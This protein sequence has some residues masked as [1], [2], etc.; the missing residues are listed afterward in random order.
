MTQIH[1]ASP[2]LAMRVLRKK[3]VEQFINGDKVVTE[4]EVVYEFKGGNLFLD[5]GTDVLADRH[6]PGEG[7]VEQDA[8]SY[9]RNHPDLGIRFKEITPVAPDPGPVYADIA[10]AV[11]AGDIA[12]LEAIGDDEFETW[13]RDEVMDRVRAAL[14][15]LKP[16]E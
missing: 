8:I 2:H 11:I 16:K 5:P 7:F 1:F 6:V 9:L 15:R 3:A 4:P 12:K 13:N 10:D 14:D